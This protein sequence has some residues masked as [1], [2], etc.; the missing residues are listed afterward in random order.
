M[1]FDGGP[2]LK[3]AVF[4]NMVIHGNDNV[5]S[6]IRVIDRLTS[7]AQGPEPPSEMPPAQFNM[8][9]VIMLTAGRARGSHELR[10]VREAP[11]GSR[12]DVWTGGILLEGENKAHNVTLQ[13][14]ETFDL[15]G[16][17]W[18]DV[19]IDGDFMT[20]MPFQIIYQPMR[21]GAG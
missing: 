8:T 16:V 19:Y 18:Y 2:Y 13:L 10:I 17:Y 14:A 1:P 12:E 7:T 4:V 5:L 9:A 6:L 11:D 20:R 15:E 21:S 3:A